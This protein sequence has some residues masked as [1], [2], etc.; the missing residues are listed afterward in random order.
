MKK[1]TLTFGLGLVVALGAGGVG[2]TVLLKAADTETVVVS[3]HNLQPYS[4]IQPSDIKMVTVP[5][6]SGI[7]GLATN[8]ADVIGKYLSYTI[9]G[10]YPITEGDLSSSGG[11][12][13]TFLTQYVKRSGQTGMLLALPVQSPLASVVQRGENIALI[14]PNGKDGSGTGTGFTTI[15]PVPVLNVLESDKGGAPS[16]LLVF[17]TEKD[18]NILAPAILNNS[19]TVGLI[20]QDGSFTAPQSIQLPSTQLQLTDNGTKNSQSTTTTAAS[21]NSPSGS[22]N[23]SSVTVITAPPAGQSGSQNGGTH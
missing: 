8:Q 16:A 17:V 18:Y 20:P 1:S 4:R 9:P 23:P 5:T 13:S 3:T 6:T 12:F 15:Q 10:G 11:S 21:N 22:G 7:Q 19:V 2:T 14:V